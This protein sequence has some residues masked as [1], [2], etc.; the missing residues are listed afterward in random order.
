M[1]IEFLW[2]DGCPNHHEARE[3][4]SEVMSQLGV[5]GPIIDINATDPAVAAETKFPG[6]PTIRV[7][8]RDIEPGYSDPG[9]YTPRCRLYLTDAGLKGVPERR[10]VEEALDAAKLKK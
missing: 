9:E 7:N 4:L 2:F 1:K 5:S 10:W 8:G 3:M 6:S